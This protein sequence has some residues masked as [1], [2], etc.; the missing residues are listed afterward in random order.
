[1]GHNEDNDPVDM[2]TSFMLHARITDIDPASMMNTTDEFLAFCYAG[3]LCGKAFGVNFIKRTV[4]TVN[5]LFPKDVVTNSIGASVDGVRLC[6]E[7]A[8]QPLVDARGCLPAS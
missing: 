2:Y 4:T 6:M 3:S 1:M 7:A 8:L 5:A